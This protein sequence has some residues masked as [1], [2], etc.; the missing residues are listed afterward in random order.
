MFL[1]IEDKKT[2]ESICLDIK[3][4]HFADEFAPLF[5]Y[6]KNIQDF[7]FNIINESED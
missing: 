7:K 2:G 5:E 1:N 6:I 4:Y 3:S